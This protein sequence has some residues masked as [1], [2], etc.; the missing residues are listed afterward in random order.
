MGGLGGLGARGSAPAAA[1]W[2]NGDGPGALGTCWGRAGPGEP[3]GAAARGRPRGAQNGA[4]RGARPGTARGRGGHGPVP[5]GH[6]PVLRGTARCRALFRRPHAKRSAAMGAGP[7]CVLP[8]GPA[9]PAGAWTGDPGSCDFFFCVCVFKKG[10][11]SANRVNK[12]GLG[13]LMDVTGRRVT[14]GRCRPS[15]CSRGGHRGRGAQRAARGAGGVLGVRRSVGRARRAGEEPARSLQSNSLIFAEMP[16]ARKNAVP[17][18][19]VAV[20][21]RFP[22]CQTAPTAPLRFFFL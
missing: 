16:P 14:S 8:H 12:H 20:P 2:G 21:L 11:R 10:N 15:T 9:K 5:A 18:G 7:G 4:G 17:H 3:R 6:G 13:K 19:S 1:T 22:Q